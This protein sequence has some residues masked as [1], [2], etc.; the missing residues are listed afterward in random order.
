[1]ANN[2]FI[3]VQCVVAKQTM[4]FAAAGI[5]SSNVNVIFEPLPGGVINSFIPGSGFNSVSGFTAG[6]GY[7]INAK[8]AMD[9]SA[10]IIP[11][12]PASGTAPTITAQPQNTSVNYGAAINLSVSATGTAPLSYQWQRNTGSG[13]VNISGATASTLTIPSATSGDAGN[14]QVIVSNS[15]GSVTSNIAIVGTF[16]SQLATP[17]GL[18]VTAV[19]PSQLNISW[20]PVSNASSYV[21]QRASNSGFTTGLVTLFD[22]NSFSYPDMGLTASTQ[23]FYRVKAT[24]AGGG[25]YADSNFATASGTT[26]AIVQSDVD[27]DAYLNAVAAVG[28]VTTTQRSA[29]TN[30]FITLKN[31][32]L[33]G[34]GWSGATSGNTRFVG[35]YPM[36][37]NTKEGAAI[38][39]ASP[40]T[41][42]IV[43][44]GTNPTVNGA[45]IKWNGTDGYGQ[46]AIFDSGSGIDITDNLA[47]GFLQQDYGGS[48]AVMG[49]GTGSS[50]TIIGNYIYPVTARYAGNIT[51]G[52]SGFADFRGIHCL[53]RYGTA[54]L[55]LYHDKTL[56]ANDTTVSA[57]LKPDYGPGVG[58][59]L[60]NYADG[61]T[62][63]IMQLAWVGYAFQTDAEYFAFAEAAHVFNTAAGRKQESVFLGDSI[64]TAFTAT[65]SYAQYI[66]TDRNWILTTF[67]TGGTTA[68]KVTPQD[69]LGAPNLIDRLGQIPAKAGS[70]HKYLMFEYGANDLGL[71]LTNYNPTNFQFALDQAVQHAH[72]V[73]GWDYADI[74]IISP[75]YF[76]QPGRNIYLAN[77][78]YVTTAADVTRHLAFVTA[79]QTVANN[80]GCKFYNAYSYMSAHGGVS[81]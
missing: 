34:A 73:K 23:Y 50:N 31:L 64:T 4:T 36:L 18:T 38:N 79:A 53:N 69:V 29:I 22:G 26:Q 13:F 33:Y 15:A 44:H 24:A 56:V 46:L 59:N 76:E 39:A 40:S 61:F 43:Y 45:G 74:V 25:F 5:D 51:A 67:A 58:V 72:N 63:Q 37:G 7:W 16:P 10:Y 47:M 80:S 3:G 42:P 57:G 55:K 81:L 77:N 35:L 30:L 62:A 48:P 28:T 12:I 78:S 71:N 19:S 75:T 27:A 60:A 17:T 21:L 70:R 52:I 9:I 41:F 49:G 66:S 1:M 65:T 11:P 14:Y 32:G 54:S 20:S 8:V 6:R 68:E 2:I